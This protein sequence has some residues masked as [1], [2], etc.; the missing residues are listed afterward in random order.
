L[1]DGHIFVSYSSADGAFAE[2][3]VRQLEIAG[4]RI[5]FAPR[6][7]RP[8][9][10]YSEQIQSA[11]EHARA[12]VVIIS[13]DANESDFVR[14]ET[15]MA[16]SRRRPIFPVRCG[17]VAPA[18][19]LA[20]FLQLRHWTEAFGPSRQNA[21]ARLG[22]ELAGISQRGERSGKSRF[23][24]VVDPADEPTRSRA[25]IPLAAV[26]CGALLLCI[27]LI[28]QADNGAVPNTV[29]ANTDSV[30]SAD[31]AANDDG[32]P[33]STAGQPNMTPLVET[34]VRYIQDTAPPPPL[35]ENYFTDN[36]MT[37]T[38]ATGAATDTTT[39]TN[40]ANSVIGM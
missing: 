16:F 29:A 38:N 40:G 10:D 5:W 8:G 9:T 1:A 17:R 2:D 28:V 34:W 14:A 20:L 6:N 33:S 18:P 27:F 3:L 31:D 35:E 32:A 25:M 7:V 12:F 21:I 13:K 15:E 19:G 11:I 37:A 22:R 4:N 23:G 24:R 39:I 26:G 36:A 30:N